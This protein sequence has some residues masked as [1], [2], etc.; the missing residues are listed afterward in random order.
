M[1][2]PAGSG[3][4][5]VCRQIDCKFFCVRF[6]LKKYFHRKFVFIRDHSAHSAQ[7]RIALRLEMITSSDKSNCSQMDVS[8]Q[9]TN[10]FIIFCLIY[11][12][13]LILT[14]CLILPLGVRSHLQDLKEKIA[15]NWPR[16]ANKFFAK[17]SPP[18]QKKHSLVE[19]GSFS[20]TG[21]SEMGPFDLDVLLP[22]VRGALVFGSC[23]ARRVLSSFGVSKC[24]LM[25][26]VAS[27]QRAGTYSVIGI[28]QR[29]AN[30]L[31]CRPL[32]GYDVTKL[33]C[34]TQSLS[35]CYPLVRR[36]VSV[37]DLG[38]PFRMLS[39]ENLHP[40]KKYENNAP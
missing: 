7:L 8:K 35:L 18:S 31:R 9:K 22:D 20:E 15:G 13:N 23:L 27:A 28:I 38:G 36:S 24:C 25:R 21:G 26:D 39:Y 11:L 1:L 32:E 17:T 16:A 10:F 37:F 14:I 12:L 4:F 3:I 6:K 29:A 19:C 34:R 30:V 33:P 5:L 40:R 2:H